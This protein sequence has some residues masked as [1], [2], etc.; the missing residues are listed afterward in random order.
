MRRVDLVHGKLALCSCKSSSTAPDNPSGSQETLLWE[1]AVAQRMMLNSGACAK[2]ACLPF[3]LMRHSCGFQ[4]LLWCLV[5]NMERYMRCTN[6]DHM[7]HATPPAQLATVILADHS[8][9]ICATSTQHQS[10]PGLETTS[11][12]PPS[13][14]I[15]T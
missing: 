6:W 12:R 1:Q 15:W 10:L 8:L 7:V 3:V 11:V 9:S 5:V 4:R 14:T 2:E 13:W